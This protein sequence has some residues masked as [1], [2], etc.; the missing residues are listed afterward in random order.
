LGTFSLPLARNHEV[1]AIENDPDLLAALEQ[2][3]A[4]SGEISPPTTLRRD[5]FAMPLSVRELAGFD[6]ALFDPPRGGAISQA[7]QMAGSSLACIIAVS[8][9]PESFAND[10]RILLDGGYD[11]V[12]LIP[13]D[14]F[15]FSPHIELVA[16][17]V[18]K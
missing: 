1:T 3:A 14:Q 17:F 6:A 12:S 13:F 15:V 11:M 8:C 7:R 4:R 16:L 10:A 9:N 18:R 5:L 2:A